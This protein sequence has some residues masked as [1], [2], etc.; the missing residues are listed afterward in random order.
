M[1]VWLAHS[2]SE[3][4][5]FFLFSFFFFLHMNFFVLC[6]EIVIFFSPIGLI[7]MVHIINR[8]YNISHTREM[9]SVLVTITCFRFRSNDC[10]VHVVYQ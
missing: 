1:C 5:Y 10:Y 2:L 9:C 6:V 3:I 7:I 8:G 4:V